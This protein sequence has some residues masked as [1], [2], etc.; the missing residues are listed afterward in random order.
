MLALIV[1]RGPEPQMETDD[2]DGLRWRIA[3]LSTKAERGP[4]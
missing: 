1:A 2:A 4:E 3:S